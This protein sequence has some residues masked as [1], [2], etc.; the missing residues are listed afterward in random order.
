MRR[1]L[2]LAL[3][4][5]GMTA[6]AVAQQIPP[7]ETK[8]TPAEQAQLDTDNKGRATPMTAAQWLARR[9]GGNDAQRKTWEPTPARTA[10]PL[11][12][13]VI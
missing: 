12:A 2:V 7:P 13:L 8:L 5:A 6:T 3:A 1:F 10:R 4:T 11:R 9:R